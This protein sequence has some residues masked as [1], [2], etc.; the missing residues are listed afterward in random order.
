MWWWWW[1]YT[2][3]LV[4]FSFLQQVHVYGSYK[5]PAPPSG[6]HTSTL[7]PNYGPAPDPR[8]SVVTD[9]EDDDEN[10]SPSVPLIPGQAAPPIHSQVSR[11]YNQP[12]Q[13]RR[14][15]PS[16]SQRVRPEKRNLTPQAK[17]DRQ[18]QSGGDDNDDDDSDNDSNEEKKKGQAEDKPEITVN[19]HQP[20]FPP[21]TNYPAFPLHF[22]TFN[23]RPQ[24]SPGGL[25]VHQIPP[26]AKPLVIVP[27]NK[28]PG[29]TTTTLDQSQEPRSLVYGG[30]GGGVGA[31]ALGG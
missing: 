24:Q 22:P 12:E 5:G 21:N 9:D 3:P 13:R 15:P 16:H 7:V 11:V 2:P 19:N 8:R 30:G 1:W 31:G 4:F 23:P 26:S 20:Q 29:L 28:I 6:S 27:I 18:I 14:K 25:F 17:Y 10:E